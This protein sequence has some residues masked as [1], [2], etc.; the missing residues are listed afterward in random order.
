MGVTTHIQGNSTVN[1]SLWGWDGEGLI[2]TTYFYS[3]FV[4]AELSFHESDKSIMTYNLSASSNA[5][6]RYLTKMMI[7]DKAQRI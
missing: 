1:E 4:K 5:W 7:A 6:T 3:N 2:K